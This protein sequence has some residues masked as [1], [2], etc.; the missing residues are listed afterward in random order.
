MKRED[1]LIK[2][3]LEK[4]QELYYGLTI[5]EGMDEKEAAKIAFEE[6]KKISK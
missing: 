3:R 6:A 2:K 1:R 5:K 4:F